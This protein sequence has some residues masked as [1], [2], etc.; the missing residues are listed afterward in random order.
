[1]IADLAARL[2]SRYVP[3]HIVGEVLGRRWTDN[4]IPVFFLVALTAFMA[5]AIP[6]FFSVG[7]LSDTSRQIGEFGLMVIGM[8]IVMLAGGIDLSVGS[9]FALAN[10]TA[11]ALISVAKWP[12]E[13]AIVATMVLGALVG[14]VNGL[15]IGYLRLRA[16]LTTL[17]MLTLTRAIVDFLLQIYSVRIASSDVE[18]DLWDFIGAGSVLG[19]PLSF[20]VLIVTAIAAH[21]ILTRLRIGWRIMAVGG[22]RRASY[23]AGIPVRGTV[24]LSYVVSG[25]LAGLAGVLYAARLS[26]A[27]PDTGLGLELTVVTAALLGGNSVGGGRGSIGKALIGAIIVSLL[28]NG[29]V[30]LGLQSG[31]S[32]MVVGLVLLFAIGIDVRWA[33]WRQKLQSKVYVSPAYLALPSIP[34]IN[35][36]SSSPYARN[37]RLRG[38]E[39][40]GLGQV[41]GPE[42]VILDGDGNLYC[43]VR[44]GDIIRF[45]APDYTRSEVYCHVGGRPLG[46]AFD[47]DGSLVVCIG[48]MGLYRV[49]KLRNPEKLT[50]E[51]NRTRLSVIDDSRMRLA[52]DLDIASDG[53]V[54]FSEATIRYG[55]EEWV[56]DAL[57]GRGN[58]RIIRYDPAS[59]ATRTIVRNL[60]FANGVCIAHDN[61]SM[62]FAETWGCRISRY[63][64]EGAKAGTIEA[65][66][67]N[68]PG[69][70]DNINRGSRGTY[71][72]ALAG[73]RTPTYDLAMTM[74]AFRRRMARRVASDE[75]LFPNVNAGCVVRFDETGRVLETLWDLEGKNHPAITSMREHR[76]C[77]YLGGVTNNR[78]GRIRLSDADPEW[79]GPA[80][81]WGA[82]A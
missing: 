53:K 77:L 75:W 45:F 65:V 37:D 4:A 18:S 1:M 78:I 51:T 67:P 29:L 48:G 36:G 66:I 9:A 43:S 26:G 25:L 7:N 22:S 79:T 3:D 71:W 32:S 8:A 70:P 81:Y 28:T 47:R 42:D 50:A 30:R 56:V 69:Y 60:L 19:V 5:E 49:D 41:D 23:N 16:F 64:L 34:A 35:V 59:G 21:I 80:S 54:Y 14:L 82:R 52:D 39:I 33:K 38:A 57:E 72:V 31:A 73:T 55:F 44:Q 61:K 58:G 63:W 12:T 2:R 40:I 17:V 74:P 20:A 46:M 68:L 76:G 27:G 6:K 13:A 10:F 24:C 15:L 11:L 62:L